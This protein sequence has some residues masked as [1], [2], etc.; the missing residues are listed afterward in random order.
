[1]LLP[2]RALFCIGEIEIDCSR[3]LDYL[4]LVEGEVRLMMERTINCV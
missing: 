3:V 4:L 1:M 2:S